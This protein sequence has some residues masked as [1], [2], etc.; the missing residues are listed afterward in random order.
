MWRGERALGQFQHS[1][2]GHFVDAGACAE[3]TDAKR[4]LLSMHDD[5]IRACRRS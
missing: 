3:V 5:R 2:F 4:D 1:V